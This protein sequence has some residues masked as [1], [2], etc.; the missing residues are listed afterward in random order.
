MNCYDLETLRREWLEGKRYDFLYF[1]KPTP[2]P[3][4]G[5]G[6]GCLGQWWPCHFTVDGVAYNCAEQYMMAGKARMFG[7]G[8]ML[9]AILDSTSPKEMKAL[10]RKV[11]GFDKGT[12]E[13]QCTQLVLRGNLEKFG[14]DP[15]LRDYLL[16]TGKTILVEASPLDRIWG[17]GIGSSNP[18]AR[19]P[20][21]WR[22][23]N[24]LGFT[25][26]K[27]RELLAAG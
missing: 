1:W 15:A 19:D 9:A 7:D 27:A 13:A 14:Q 24:L 17:I 5:L 25:L 4:G 16:G 3:D 2:G 20:M 22:G 18:D 21:K 12:W 10:G 6:E 11:R 26:T 8:E 23:K